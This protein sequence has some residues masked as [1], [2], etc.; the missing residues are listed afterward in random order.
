VGSPVAGEF[1]VEILQSLVR[2]PSVNPGVPETAVAERVVEWLS[3]TGAEIATVEFAPGRPSVAAVLRGSHPGPT[4]VLN[5]HMDTVPVGDETLWTTSPYGGEVRNGFVYGRGACDMKSGLAIEVAMAHCFAHVREHAAGTLVLHFAAG[6]E[7]GEPGTL[8][9]INAGYRGDY[10]IALEPTDL[11]V[12]TATRGVA[13]YVIRIRGQSAHAGSSEADT[14]P[15][16]ILKDVLE[17]LHK[18]DRH[19]RMLHHALLPGGSATPTI[20]RAGI[21]ENTIPED[22]EITIDRRLLPGETAAGE[23]EAIVARLHGIKKRVPAFDFEVRQ[24]MAADSAEVDVSSSFVALMLQAVSDV[25]GVP[26]SAWGAP[27]G[28]DGRFLVNEAG[29]EAVTFGPGRIDEC[30]CADERVEI[31]QLEAAAAVVWRVI[32][33]VLALPP[34]GNSG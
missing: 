9:L 5:S 27:F 33:S 14:N 16:W 19:A 23:A 18:Y 31:R 12:A 11:R 4:I 28:S 1:L 3:T 34:K 7:R 15:I 20:V 25:R 21:N 26:A 10:G 22:C 6:E 2:I 13:R 8:S 30:H 17:E 24:L 32:T 29:M